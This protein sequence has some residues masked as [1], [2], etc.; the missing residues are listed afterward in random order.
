MTQAVIELLISPLKTSYQA[1]LEVI[2]VKDLED[3][4]DIGLY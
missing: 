3:L 2:P 1:V 4:A